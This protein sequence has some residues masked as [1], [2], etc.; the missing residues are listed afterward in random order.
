MECINP[1]AQKY[2][3][4]FSSDEDPQLKSVAEFTARWSRQSQMLSGHLQ[5]TFLQLIS[6]LVQPDNIL[7]IGT[8][9]G[10]SAL[11]LAKGLRD[12]G[13]VHTIELRKEESA[14]AQENF[15]NAGAAEKIILHTGNAL[16]IIPTL[17][18]TWDLVFIDADK[19]GYINYY[20]LVLPLMR[21]GG[22]ILA[23]NVLYHGE[24]LEDN[25]SGKNARAIQAFN[26]YVHADDSVEKVL[27]TI[28][29]GLLMIVKK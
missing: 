10:Y 27:L 8:F 28:R 24:V 4:R 11:C 14:V 23:D 2:A 7:E 17:T 26:E 9:T 19:A 21:K 15:N 13:Q 22:V 25:A 29:D 18:R 20:K 12:G 3:E 5:G 16:D 1:L 6:G